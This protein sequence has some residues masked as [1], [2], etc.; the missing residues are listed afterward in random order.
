MSKEK[1]E[2]MRPPAS[3]QPEGFAGFQVSFYL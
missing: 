3:E 2:A 1:K